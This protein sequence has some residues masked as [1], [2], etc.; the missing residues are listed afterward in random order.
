MMKSSMW[1]IFALSSFSLT[2]QIATNPCPPSSVAGEHVVQSGETLYGI[3]KKYKTTVAKLCEW[4]SLQE[5]G[6]LHPCDRLKVET[7]TPETPTETAATTPNEND[8][9]KNYYIAALQP[10][11]AAKPVKAT[12][13]SKSDRYKS[14]HIVKQGETLDAIATRYGYTTAR[15]LLVNNLKDAKLKT[16]QRLK[17]SDCECNN[18]EK[19]TPSV[20]DKKTAVAPPK[21]AA[22]KPIAKVA[23]QVPEKKAVEKPSENIEKPAPKAQSKGVVREVDNIK[24]AAKPQSEPTPNYTY[25]QNS[26]YAPLVHI[27]NEGE[28]PASIAKLYGL[29]AGDIMMMNNLIDNLPLKADAK[30]LIE[31][32]NEPKSATSTYLL[33]DTVVTNVPFDTEQ[34]KIPY[35]NQSGAPADNAS[36]APAAS[37]QTPTAA[38]PNAAQNTNVSNKLSDNRAD[39]P[40]LTHATSMT[41]DEIEMV[42]EINLIRSNPSA[43][44][45]Y[46]E[47][48]IK[49]L[50]ANGDWMGSS[51]TAAELI[52]ELKKT[53]PLSVLEPKECV[54]VA[55]KKH[56]DEQRRKRDLGHKG[57]DGSNSWDRILRQCTDLKD[58]GENLIGGQANIRRAVITLLVDHGIPDHLH[59]KTILNPDWNFVACHK[60]GTVGDM[61]HCWIQNFGY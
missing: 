37:T 27:T 17:L 1:S 51:G 4:N 35:P 47:E 6:I 14:E 32:R 3:S 22:E 8:V 56:G 29:T 41:T 44:V 23:E 61:P 43:Y 24:P 16:G 58:G 28:T 46:V 5:S 26:Q 9:P 36:P 59:R 55:A 39:I 13:I 54:Y 60:L 10:K 25:F 34:I 7:P 48:Y 30:L 12:T 57:N 42:K 21:P 52:E 19:K 2:A 50:K 15:L 45:P 49:Y 31:N 18:E 53:P 33:S 11:G 40:P 20:A 38:T